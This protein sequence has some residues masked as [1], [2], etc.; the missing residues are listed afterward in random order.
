MTI[1]L[2]TPI[3]QDMHYI[4]W[5]WGDEETMQH[6]GGPVQ[7]TDE[8]A[9]EWFQRVIDPGGMTE[10]Y[11]LISNEDQHLVGEV[12]YHRFEPK[13]GTAMFNL[14][15]AGSECGK[16]YARAAMRIFLHTFFNEL[17]GRIML[18]DIALSNLRGQEVLLRFGFRHD[19]SKKDIFRAAITKEKFNRLYSSDS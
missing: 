3:W 4:R 8:Q 17:G 1:E 15:I 19:P 12:S 18:D 6:V 10:R 9:L 5:L 13:T 16:G 7:L 11:M 14:K 2:R